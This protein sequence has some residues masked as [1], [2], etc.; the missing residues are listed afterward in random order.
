MKKSNWL[1][2]SSDYPN[3]ISLTFPRGYKIDFDKVKT[4]DDIKL[5]LEAVDITVFPQYH[6]YDEI[7]HLLKED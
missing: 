2:E 4:I 5:L 3:G 1:I 7:K 6:R